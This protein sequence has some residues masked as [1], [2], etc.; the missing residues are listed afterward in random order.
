MRYKV[1][2]LILMASRYAVVIFVAAGMYVSASAQS[3]VTYAQARNASAPFVHST[4]SSLNLSDDS[5]L[6]QIS[7]F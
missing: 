4:D 2:K 7:S 5:G 6:F 1:T 3:T